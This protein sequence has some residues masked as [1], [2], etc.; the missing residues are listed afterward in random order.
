[1]DTL[2]LG[3]AAIKHVLYARHGGKSTDVKEVAF[4][5]QQGVCRS[6]DPVKV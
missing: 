3:A 4:K 6:T 1:M 2:V 5:V